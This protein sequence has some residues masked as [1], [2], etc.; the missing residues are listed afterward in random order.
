MTN[1]VLAVLAAFRELLEEHVG[2]DA[3]RLL[4]EI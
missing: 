3:K 4:G 2:V 1:K